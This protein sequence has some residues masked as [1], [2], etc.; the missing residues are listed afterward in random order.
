MPGEH[1]RLCETWAPS[2][3]QSGNAERPSCK[4]AESDSLAERHNCGSSIPPTGVE[5]KSQGAGTSKHFQRFFAAHRAA[6]GPVCSF[7]IS[8]FLVSG[9][10]EGWMA[11][12][13]G[14]RKRK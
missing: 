1:R 7:I 2:W 5:G 8:T 14:G 3:E 10:T 4:F 9:W 13:G 6:S 11:I 12:N